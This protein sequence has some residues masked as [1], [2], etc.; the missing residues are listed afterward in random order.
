[1]GLTIDIRTKTDLH[2]L[3]WQLAADGKA[4][5]LISSDMPEMVALADR[6]LVMNDYAVVGEV[7]NS[8]DYDAVSADIMAMIH[9][10]EE[11]A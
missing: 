8:H 5:L 1:M 2:E 7:A 3:I 9:T 4:V 11:A 10:T 6:I